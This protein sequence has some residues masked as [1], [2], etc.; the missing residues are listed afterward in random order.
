MNHVKPI[1]DSDV[2]PMKFAPTRE[3]PLIPSHDE[4]LLLGLEGEESHAP[5]AE[6]AGS[7][8]IARSDA[9]ARDAL[10]ATQ[11]RGSAEMRPRTAASHYGRL[12]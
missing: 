3:L 10:A 5:I 7:A 4:D 12:R 1:S 9:G 11:K 8:K 2:Y 6:C